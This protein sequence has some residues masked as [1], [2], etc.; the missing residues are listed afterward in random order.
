MKKGT[1]KLIIAVLMLVTIC[2]YFV[3]G[4]YARYAESITGNANV[5]VA[6]WAVAF[7]DGETT[8]ANNFNLNFK[9]TD[10]TNVVSGKVAPGTSATA[11]I[12]VDLTGTEVAVDYKAEIDEKAL[13]AKFN[14]A[15]VTVSTSV[16]GSTTSKEGT[17]NL[18]EDKAFTETNGKVPIVITLTWNGEEADSDDKNGKDTAMGKGA[19]GTAIELPV[20]L[21]LQ[22]HIG[23]AH[24]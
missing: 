21:K 6:K 24:Q 15:D 13:E 20:T 11:T 4:T 22:Q 2:L 3:S 19:T 7:K 16:S 5:T 10:N 8:L 18:I 17:I 14:G 9:V 23:V 1:I 12:E